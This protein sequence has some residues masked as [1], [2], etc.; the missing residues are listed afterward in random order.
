MGLHSV[1]S[2]AALKKE[3]VEN[4]VNEERENN[5][6]VQAGRGGDAL[7]QSDLGQ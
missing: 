6:R 2:R 3:Y 1:E 7:R 5:G 4:S